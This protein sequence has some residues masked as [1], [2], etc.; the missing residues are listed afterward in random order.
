M[1]NEFSN[2]QENMLFYRNWCIFDFII[3]YHKFLNILY[4]NYFTYIYI[5]FN[6]KTS[7][8]IA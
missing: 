3:A 1:I 8:N 6:R 2:N 5:E 7:D 4:A